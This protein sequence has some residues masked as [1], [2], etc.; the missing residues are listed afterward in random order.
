MDMR[1]IQIR[2]AEKSDAVLIATVVVM[3]IDGTPEQHPF[4]PIF[5]ELASREV[6]QY[7]YR[8][9]L[10]AE[11]NGVAVGAIVGYDGARLH[12]LRQPIYPLIKQHLGKEI[13]IEEE[14]SAGEFYLDSVAV[15]PGYRS[16][17]IGRQLL[18]K[19][20]DKAFG[21]G[22]SRVGLLVDMENPRAEKLYRS[23]GFERVNSTTFLGHPMWHLQVVK[24]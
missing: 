15:L 8:N 16:M 19:M 6:A 18:E 9:A 3:A 1:E 24:K 23:L 7:S 4:Y 13:E 20:R 10:V 14:C 12:E 5:L 2:K 22:H 17:G 21:E 11:V